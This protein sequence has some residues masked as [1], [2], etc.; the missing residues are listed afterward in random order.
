[1][2]KNEPFQTLGR[3]RTFPQGGLILMLQK[4]SENQS[5]RDQQERHHESRNEIGGSQL[6]RLQPV[7]I[8]LVEG[9]QQIG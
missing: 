2:T 8:A 9:V 6:P 5:V 3:M 7:G 1:M 4:N